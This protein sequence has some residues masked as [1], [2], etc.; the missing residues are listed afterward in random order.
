M[1]FYIL[2]IEKQIIKIY[3][4][5]N[6]SQRRKDYEKS[7]FNSFSNFND[8]IN[9]LCLSAPNNKLT[10][11]NITKTVDVV[12]EALKT[13]DTKTV[14]T[15]V[16]STTLDIILT[17]ASKKDQFKKLGIAMFENLT[18][19]IKEIDTDGQTVTLSVKNKDLSKVASDYTENLLE[20]YSGLAGMLE[21][22]KGITDD[23]WLNS[24]L[25]VLTKGINE[26]VMKDE[27]VEITL[28]LEQKKDRLV[29]TFTES[30]EDAVS[31]GALTAIKKMMS[32]S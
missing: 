14:K 16:D 8:S 28:S 12:F 17:Y 4:S 6:Y 29:F 18:Y 1:I 23:A 13:F 3:N 9:L 7:H 22:A 5:F 24:N 25:A 27:A 19:E 11:K 30:S 31:G 2:N 21:L 10:E 32:F 15:Y 20:Q 26:A